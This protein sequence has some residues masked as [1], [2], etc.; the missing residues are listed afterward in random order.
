MAIS[1]SLMLLSV[2]LLLSLLLKPVAEK[3]NIP[4]AGLLVITGF[5]GSEAVI[6]LGIYPN[7]LKMQ[8]SELSTKVRTRRNVK[9][10]TSPCRA[11]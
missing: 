5:V 6:Y 9:A 11:L 4:F 8:I 7:Y 1:T 3:Y 2:M 10:M